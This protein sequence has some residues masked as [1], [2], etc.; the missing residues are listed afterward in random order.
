MDTKHSLRMQTKIGLGLV[1]TSKLLQVAGVEL[2]QLIWRELADNP[3][4]ELVSVAGSPARQ[5]LVHSAGSGLSSKSAVA[6]HSQAMIPS[7]VSAQEFDRMAEQV[8]ATPSAIDQLIAQA[9]LM[10]DGDDLEVAIYL[11]QSLDGHGYLRSTPEELAAELNISPTSVE[12]VVQ[13]LHQLDPPGI[14]ARNLHECLF[15][16]S[17]H[18]ETE[19]GDCLIVRRILTEVWADFT[20][21]RWSRVAQKLHLPLS[22]VE[23]ARHFMAQNFYPYPLQL[24]EDGPA[25]HDVLAYADMIIYRQSGC[26]PSIYTLEIPHGEALELK[27]SA[28]FEKAL[29]AGTGAAGGLSAVE[30]AWIRTQVDRARVFI[31]ALDQRWA[32]LRRIGEYLIDYQVEFLNF[33]PRHLKP[34][35]R[36]AVAM[37]LGLHESTVSRAITEKS[38]QLPDGQ[39]T[40][41]SDFFNASLA[42]KEAIRQL[43][44]RANKPLN[45]HEI[46]N[47]LQTEGLNLARRTIAKY[48]QQLNIPPSYHQQHDRA[49]SLA[50]RV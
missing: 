34:L 33:G 38:V 14:C 43:L 6:G 46:A 45:D 5:R 17:K 30:M 1:I 19:G 31:T 7:I 36:A 3:A 39:L 32:T 16:Q 2:E 40:P 44:A 8:T 11:L 23:E 28:C 35:T 15:L 26:G 24:V 10:V 47:H 22:A 48:R 21:Q 29:S 9:A 37:A 20:N 18:L 49:W 13:I 12:R 27:V 41:L 50:Q 42:T 25:N 4:L